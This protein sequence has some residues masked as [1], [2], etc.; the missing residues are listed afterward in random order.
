M[1][2]MDGF[3]PVDITQLTN[4]LLLQHLACHIIEFNPKFTSGENSWHLWTCGLK[5]YIQI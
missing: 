4:H 1:S 2:N 3:D 5:L